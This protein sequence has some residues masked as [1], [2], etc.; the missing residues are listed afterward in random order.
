MNRLH[1]YTG[2][3][4]GKTSAAMGLALR[5][6]GHGNAVLVAQFMKTGNS[7]ELTALRKLPGA[8]VITAPPIQGFTFNMTDAQRLETARQQTAFVQEAMEAIRAH[9]PKTIVL[10]E[11]GVAAALGMV[12]DDAA[13]ALVDAALAA[14]E[15]AVTGHPMPAWLEQRADYLSRIQSEKHPY[16]TEGLPAR[17]GVEW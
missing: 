2:G 17:E 11:L 14:G 5:S 3:G 15:T 9:T 4:Q 12:P 8:V 10:D 7:G 1:V 16:D 6:L 13:Q